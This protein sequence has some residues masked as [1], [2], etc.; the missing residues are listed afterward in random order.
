LLVVSTATF[1]ASC[2]KD[3]QTSNT[4]NVG[5]FM[6]GKIKICNKCGEAKQIKEF[7][8]NKYAQDGYQYQCKTCN[9]IYRQSDERKRS[10]K[11]YDQSDKG[12]QT[13]KRYH[14]SQKGKRTKKR[15]LRTDKG[16]LSH[17]RNETIRRTRKTKAGGSYI[18]IEWFNLCK[19]YGFHCLK[20][21]KEF[22]FE[23]LTLDHIKPVS[24]GG[25]SF[26]WNIQPLC[27]KCNSNKGAKEIDYRKTLPDWIDRDDPIWQQDTLF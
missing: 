18:A 17:Q 23:Q 24:K 12:K 19:F 8:K 5:A 20:C 2:R 14:Q 1:L 26:I 25:S 7:S 6:F 10:N 15:F 9:K 13:K 22:P 3:C 27:G 4:Q 16:K 11:K 21:N